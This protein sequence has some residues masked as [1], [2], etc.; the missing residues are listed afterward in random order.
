[1]KKLMLCLCLMVLCMAACVTAQASAVPSA[2]NF[3][4]DGKTVKTEVYNIDGNNYF[5]L[6]DIA[7]LLKGTQSGFSVDYDAGTGMISISGGSDY[8]PV[9][10]ELETGVDHSASCVASPQKLLVN[11]KDTQI[12][13]YNIGGNNFFKLRD[14]GSLLSF[15]VGYQEDTKTA[16]VLSSV[17]IRH[18]DYSDGMPADIYFEIPVFKGNSSAL[19]RVNQFFADTEKQYA[20]GENLA[21]ARELISGDLENGNGPTQEDPYLAGNEATVHTL[22]AN[23]ISVSIDYSWF[24]G[25]VFDYGSTGYTFNA[26]N[27]DRLFLNDVLDGS[28]QQIKESIIRALL[29]Q[30]PGVEGA[31]VMDTPMD[32][33]RG[34]DIKDIDYIVSDGKVCV[35]FDKYEIAAGM[36]GMFVVTLPDALSAQ[37][38]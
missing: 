22:S 6:R 5:K 17:S 21:Y 16:I 27:G 8:A 7:M 35:I 36:A 3:Q 25:G 13:A 1:M 15:Y 30:Y 33:I 34:M 2:Q 26:K 18:T 29:Q 12:K 14:L 20:A 4:V 32:T 11:G 23:L 24:M 28:D 38:A 9:G 31:G 19:N 37:F 10:G